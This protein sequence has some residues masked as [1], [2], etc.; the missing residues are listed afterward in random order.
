MHLAPGTR[1]G[2]YEIL[3]PV[4]AG[5]MGEVYR[6]RDTRLGRDVAIK[7]SKDQFSE[8]FEHEARAVA[9][10]NH[11]NICQL[12][13]VGPNYLV[14][15]LIDGVPLKGP[16]P[17]E[18]AIDY[19]RQIL[20]ALDAAHQKGITHRDLKPG[21]I[22]VT[23]QGIK[24]LDFGLAKQSGPL[25]ETELT[26]AMTQQGQL[27]GTLNYMSPEQLQS[28]EA[29]ARSDI[30]SF[31]LVLH[32][33]LTGKRAFEGA[34]AAS[35]IAAILEREPPSVAGVAPPALDRLL[36][37]C[38]AKDPEQRWQSAR[39]LR[40]A[41]DLAMA[42][43]AGAPVARGKPLPWIVAAVLAIVAA[44]ALWAL[45][46]A[47]VAVERAFRFHVNVP[48][49][50]EF[51][52]ASNGNAIS[53]DGR[54][55]A[56]VAASGGT[57]K[58][59]VQQLDSLT[60]RELPGT[61]GAQFPFWSP[62]SRSIGFFADGKLKRIDPSGGPAA[63]LTE[64]TNAR[65]GAWS[66]D[67]TIIFAP[68]TTGGLQKIPASGGTQTLYTQ[69]DAASPEVN[70]R[71]PQFLP[72]GRKFLYMNQSTDGRH[73]IYLVVSEIISDT[74]IYLASVNH[75][76]EKRA[77]VETES[78]ALY[79]PPHLRHPGYLLWLRQASAFAQA[80]DPDSGQFSG[81]PLPVPG[82]ERIAFVSLSYNSGFS[83]S[84]DGTILAGNGS[85]LF[86]LS[87]LSREGKVLSSPSQPGNYLGLR[88]SPD[89]VRTALSVINSSGGRD[90]YTLDFARG[91]QTHV[92]SGTGSLS[93]LWSPDGRK[94]VYYQVFGTSIFQRDANGAG[95]PDTLL[96]SSRSVYADDFSPDGHTLL[97]EQSEGAG[98]F[99]LWLLPYPPSS[100]S[101]RKPALY[102]KSPAGAGAF[103]A[104]F[105]PDGKW[106]AYA[107]SE[108]GPQQI[109]VQSF[110]K[111]DARVQVSNSGGGFVRWRKDGKELFYRAPDGRLMVA[112][113]RD[114]GHGLEFG[115]PAPLRITVPPAG[116]RFYPY[117]VAAD[118]RILALVPER[119]EDAPLTVLVNWQ[120]GLKK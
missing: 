50:A 32:E 47:P 76:Q 94:I 53:P 113:V 88:I 89:G 8:R 65:G 119:S 3:A 6:A 111:P 90:I 46:R 118:G 79:A 64:A 48:P 15:E 95:S 73:R 69:L 22:L 14:M 19:A 87:W 17:L 7:V 36:S 106:V 52:L 1:L 42:P 54:S 35:V 120:A 49:G 41:L 45:W 80:F 13:D 67:G 56:F 21:N 71:W 99:D 18:R 20:D 68:Q 37:R 16:L 66:E 30:F 4:G 26:Q 43:Q 110:P 31:G 117:D 107:S 55:I 70:H 12:S 105:S 112:A 23:R 98:V 82:A 60:A 2:P 58:L 72:G 24:L 25:K 92:T 59:W 101:G 115:T 83:V 27:V 57:P 102:L 77:I 78:A 91:I 75:P 29:D 114:S 34:S 74:T 38:L 86:R 28:K 85:N 100:A 104:Q 9:A 39:D 97:Y 109:Y 62:D 5:G 108:S 116:G 44:V 10:L 84:N 51:V 103:N 61:D 11:P 40:A 96:E 93:A 81:D 33:M 63:V